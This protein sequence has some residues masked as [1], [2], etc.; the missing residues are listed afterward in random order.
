MYS[1]TER[2]NKNKKKVFTN[3][4]SIP[5]KNGVWQKGCGI[6]DVRNK[7][8][9]CR[10]NREVERNSKSTKDRSGSQAAC[11]IQRVKWSALN[12][13]LKELIATKKAGFANYLVPDSKKEV[14]VKLTEGLANLADNNAVQAAWDAFLTIPVVN[15]PIL[16]PDQKI[17]HDAGKPIPPD[18]TAANLYH[19]C[20]D[21]KTAKLIAASSIEARS[22]GESY[23]KGKKYCCF[24]PTLQG[25]AALGGGTTV[26]FKVKT[27]SMGKYSFLRWGAGGEPAGTEVRSFSNI[28][29]V[30]LEVLDGGTWVDTATFLQNN[31]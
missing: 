17:F 22:G 14:N 8:T 30:D 18:S 23:L 28:A 25:T 26:V 6:V 1:Q 21:L 3:T 5:K 12:K 15:E 2:L 27:S 4:S 20:G 7:S 31:A 9:V 13:D 10:K 11:T 16:R 29:A 19:E 24:A